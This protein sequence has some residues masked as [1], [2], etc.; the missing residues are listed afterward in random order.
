[1]WHVLAS[2]KGEGWAATRRRGSVRR[3]QDRGEQP[4][5]ATLGRQRHPA[6]EDLA[7]LTDQFKELLVGQVQR[8]LP[9][10]DQI[11]AQVDVTAVQVAVEITEQPGDEC[12]ES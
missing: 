4:P 3:Q 11:A 1:M 2:V 7:E 8:D 9:V 10:A 12:G 5:A 6:G